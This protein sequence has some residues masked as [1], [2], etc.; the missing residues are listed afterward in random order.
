MVL[1]QFVRR[2][3]ELASAAL[4][5]GEVDTA[6]RHQL[7]ADVARDAIPAGWSPPAPPWVSPA[8]ILEAIDDGLTTAAQF[9]DGGG[10]EADTLTSLRHQ[11]RRVTQRHG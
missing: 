3:S 6:R 9:V 1:Q 2:H 5:A 10:G 11:I 8:A 4:S 7:L